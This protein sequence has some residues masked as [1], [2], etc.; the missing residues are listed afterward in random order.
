MA[1]DAPKDIPG[2][3]E[4]DCER[5]DVEFPK[6][7]Y[8]SNMVAVKDVIQ[9]YELRTKSQFAANRETKNFASN[10][11]IFSALPK[12]R[13]TW[14]DREGRYEKIPNDGI[15]FIVVGKR[16]MSC[17]FGPT[18]RSKATEKM[19]NTNKLKGK[20]NRT[21]AQRSVN[22][23]AQI[24]I[25]EIHKFPEF[26][27]QSDRNTKHQREKMMRELKHALIKQKQIGERRFYVSL[28]RMKDHKGHDFEKD[29]CKL[30]TDY[31]VIR[32]SDF[33]YRRIFDPKKLSELIAKY[34]REE[35]FKDGPAPP[36]S[37]ARFYPSK[38]RILNII[39]RKKHCSPDFIF[40]PREKRSSPSDPSEHNKSKKRKEDVYDTKTMRGNVA[41]VLLMLDKH[42]I[43][44]AGEEEVDGSSREAEAVVEGDGR[45]RKLETEKTLSSH[46]ENIQNIV[47][48]PSE[49][50]ELPAE[51][52][53][54]LDLL[55]KV[56]PLIVFS[57]QS[58]PV[59]RLKLKLEQSINELEGCFG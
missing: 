53:S 42:D 57:N 32:N 58:E 33:I 48:D 29:I 20:K 17:T 55:E 14:Q 30:R 15:P 5:I 3:S 9:N 6:L 46:S 51:K 23:P 52:Q 12:H 50:T 35:L 44:I 11:S 56:K 34:V 38:R 19:K 10:W 1:E 7:F 39:S 4:E 40:S 54:C 2:S 47:V 59:A 24:S 27:L 31:R 25:R 28:P 21:V 49:V 22:C 13:I 43:A 18:Y 41:E 45:I 16:S 37:D 36:V 26:S 8:V